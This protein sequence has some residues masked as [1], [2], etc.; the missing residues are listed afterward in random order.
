[1]PFFQGGKAIFG[2]MANSYSPYSVDFLITYAV[3]KFLGLD[4]I[5]G[6]LKINSWRMVFLNLFFAF[7]SRQLAREV[8]NSRYSA[9]FVFLITLFVGGFFLPHRPIFIMCNIYSPWVLLYATKVICRGPERLL[10][11]LFV[12]AIF[13]CAGVFH[14][15]NIQS[16]LIWP[17]IALYIVSLLIFGYW[18]PFIL[19]FKNQ[20]RSIRFRLGI[21]LVLLTIVSS[22]LPLAW[23]YN[24]FNSFNRKMLYPGET[25]EVLKRESVYN[26]QDYIDERFEWQKL[27]SFFMPSPQILETTTYVTPGMPGIFVHNFQYLSIPAAFLMIIGLV[28][29]RNK[30]KM[31]IIFGVLFY[32][33]FTSVNRFP[34]FWTAL[35]LH[36]PMTRHF[37]FAQLHLAP[38]FALIAGMGLDRIIALGREK[39]WERAHSRLLIILIVGITIV[40]LMA[41][42]MIGKI[43]IAAINSQ[44]YSS[45]QALIYCLVF[46]AVSIF[47]IYC[48]VSIPKSRLNF[49]IIFIVALLDLYTFNRISQN[50]TIDS[51]RSRSSMIYSQAVN[52]H[53]VLPDLDVID[54]YYPYLPLE[55]KAY[56]K[57]ETPTFY[58]PMLY[59][60]AIVGNKSFYDLLLNSVPDARKMVSGYTLPRLFLADNAVEDP[61]GNITREILSEKRAENLI[62]HVV[63][64]NGAVTVGKGTLITKD[65]LNLIERPRTINT[66]VE[67]H[68]YDIHPD[69]L[70]TNIPFSKGGVDDIFSENSV[71]PL[72][73]S[74]SLEKDDRWWMEIDFG[75]GHGKVVN[76]IQAKH[77]SPFGSR[78]TFL[79]ASNDRK[80]WERVGYLTMAD[81]DKSVPGYKVWH[82]LNFQKYRFYRIYIDQGESAIKGKSLPKIKLGFKGRSLVSPLQRE[83]KLQVPLLRFRS[84]GLTKDRRYNIFSYYLPRSQGIDFSTEP[85]Q[86][87]SFRNSVILASDRREK[88]SGQMG[89]LGTEINLSPTWDDKWHSD[90]LYQISNK[91]DGLLSINVPA[92]ELIR[93]R[94]KIIKINLKTSQTGI[95]VL[96]YGADSLRVEVNHLKPSWL[97]YADTWDKYW[98]SKVNGIPTPT[99]KA[100]LQFKAVYVPKG[101]QIVELTHKPRPFINLVLLTYALQFM[102]LF[103][104]VCTKRTPQVNT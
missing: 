54:N 43:N 48:A 74:S 79:Q 96:D 46:I 73:T 16:T 64:L 14:Q 69:M 1:M 57:W 92:S 82:T 41:N 97:Y 50:Y 61:S 51:G 37:L 34:L 103:L 9:D 19:A 87:F 102:L 75:E 80:S 56:E 18:Q 70:T 21:I 30:L 55:P 86:Q 98:E 91:A 76:Y 24:Y 32:L 40:A 88:I 5:F 6:L 4:Q 2:D 29:G 36:Y 59:R 3:S 71:F 100:N 52:Y 68:F 31:P 95:K 28:F 13:I 12:M 39:E 49:Y 11:N 22:A 84:G 47:A 53:T 38:L 99:L 62:N 10:H 66:V 15:F 72:E 45:A 8:L 20:W 83:V 35:N 89:Y 42:H 85:S 23:Q 67:K 44:S 104:S 78:R 90:N 94:K 58:F 17:Y 77:K 63:F 93:Y 101:K 27:L 65:L 81:M 25:V 33:L 7:G 26:V 60:H